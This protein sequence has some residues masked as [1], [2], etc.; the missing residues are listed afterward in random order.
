MQHPAR[1]FPLSSVYASYPRSG[2]QAGSPAL[3]LLRRPPVK[4]GKGDTQT[5][6]LQ[7]AAKN[8]RRQMRNTSLKGEQRS[9]KVV[10]EAG[11]R[12][13]VHQGGI[14]SSQ[15]A[16][17][18]RGGEGRGWRTSQRPGE[19]TE[20]GRGAQALDT[21]LGFP[22]MSGPKAETP[23]PPPDGCWWRLVGWSL[24]HPPA[25]GAG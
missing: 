19:C 13:Q 23:A 18:R 14:V 8:R 7:E 16:E 4:V 11:G 3:I 2:P 21:G 5:R 10:A 22:R 15:V 25:S 12:G 6:A 9:E 24:G 17:R 20:P 1:G